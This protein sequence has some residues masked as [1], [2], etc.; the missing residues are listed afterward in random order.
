MQN[1][2]SPLDI[3]NNI[4]DEQEKK[5]RPAFP[6]EGQVVQLKSGGPLLTVTE[7]RYYTSDN[8][9]PVW[10]F[11]AVYFNV[12]TGMLETVILVP[13]CCKPA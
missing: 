10:Q 3:I 7:V 4:L 2:Q 6:V 5:S 9:G 12:V 8:T 13:T 1:A 11:D